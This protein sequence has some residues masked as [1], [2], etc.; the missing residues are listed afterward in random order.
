[1]LKSALLFYQKLVA[2]LTSLGFE[3]NPYDPCIANKTVKGKQL[4]VLWHVDDIIVALP[5]VDS[6]MIQNP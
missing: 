2:D 6:E 4:T 1:M 3:L 5:Q